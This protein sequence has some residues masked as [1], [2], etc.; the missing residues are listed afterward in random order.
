M[1]HAD[2]LHAASVILEQLQ[3]A[4]KPVPRQELIQAI[5]YTRPEW[6][7]STAARRFRDGRALLVRRGWPVLSVGGGFVLSN[8]RALLTQAA[9]Q[10]EAA[11]RKQWREARRLRQLVPSPQPTLFAGAQPA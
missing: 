2:V 1:T 8:D 9:R 7:V 3:E 4:T 5:H 10:K 11:A 6:S